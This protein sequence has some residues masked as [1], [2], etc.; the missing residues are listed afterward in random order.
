MNWR[1]FEIQK[2][3]VNFMVF[4]WKQQFRICKLLYLEEK[5]N[6]KE[7]Q[8]IMETFQRQKTVINVFIHL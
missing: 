4:S 8:V 3:E 7:W 2:F 6:H 5:K 1:N